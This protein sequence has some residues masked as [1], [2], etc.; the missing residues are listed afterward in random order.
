M[1]DVLLKIHEVA[2]CLGV[3]RRTVDRMLAAGELVR[4][5]VGRATRVRESSLL[6]FIQRN[7]AG[8]ESR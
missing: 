2:A 4:V 6:R 8:S 5:K 7:T 3:S 1:D